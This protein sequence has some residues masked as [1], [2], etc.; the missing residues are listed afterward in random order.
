MIVKVNISDLQTEV[1][2]DM[3][4]GGKTLQILYAVER[5]GV[6]KMEPDDG[7]EWRLA[8]DQLR[9]IAGN[10]GYDFLEQDQVYWIIDASNTIKY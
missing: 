2:E 8:I 1:P 9:V 7:P 5:H 3:I 6:V 10:V 4:L